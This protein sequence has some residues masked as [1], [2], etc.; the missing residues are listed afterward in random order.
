MKNLNNIPR[1]TLFST[2]LKGKKVLHVGCADYPFNPEHNLHLQL[3]DAGIDADGLDINKEGI[4][5][6]IDN[7]VNSKTLTTS[8]AEV[9]YG[10]Y[11]VVLVPEVIEHVGNVQQFF[12]DL[13]NLGAKTYIITV[14]CIFQCADKGIFKIWDIAHEVV[15]PEHVCWYSPRTLLRTIEANTDW[16]VNDIFW[17]NGI[18]VGVVCSTKQST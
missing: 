5:K 11:E 17:N 16:E 1:I 6:L 9:P 3:L 7:G 8:F 14:P 2:L 15:H 10:K 13:H 12:E 18:S 4:Q